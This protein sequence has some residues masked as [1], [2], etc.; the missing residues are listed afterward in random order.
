MEK[1]QELEQLKESYKPEDGKEHSL[2]KMGEM[3]VG[4]LIINM[5]WPAVLSMLIQALYNVVDS[6]FVSLISEQA[7]AAVTYIFPIQML[8]IS[9]GVGT[10]V[11]INS[12][13]SRRLGANMLDDANMAQI[14]DT[15]CH[16]LIGFYLHS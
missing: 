10:G 5:S 11:G 16:F 14:T 3:P 13:I 1:E 7:L 15:D 2:N 6:F 8:L 9:V 4:K 12:L